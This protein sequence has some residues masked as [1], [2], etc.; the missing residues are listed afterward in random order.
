MRF[1]IGAG[2][3]F[4]TMLATPMIAKADIAHQTCASYFGS[5]TDIPEDAR[6]LLE[7]GGRVEICVLDQPPGSRYLRINS[8]PTLGLQG[9]CQYSERILSSTTRAEYP[10]GQPTFTYMGPAEAGH[11]PGQSD[12]RYI[13]TTNVSEGFFLEA[14]R[15]VGRLKTSAPTDQTFVSLDLVLTFIPKE[16]NAEVIQKLR[17]RPTF[18]EESLQAWVRGLADPAL[19]GI[20]LSD[21]LHGRLDG[22]YEIEV[23][24]Q[25]HNWLLVADF[26]A[27]ALRIVTIGEVYY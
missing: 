1:S 19:A 23:R 7:T 13:P 25:G 24:D 18:Y 22:L 14:Q 10:K 8:K 16:M 5:E 15:L 3:V 11:C 20:K 27:G 12:K 6:A 21:R 2:A 17:E 26:F 9:V 4:L